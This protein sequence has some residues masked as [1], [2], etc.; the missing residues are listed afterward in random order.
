MTHSNT[1]PQPFHPGSGSHALG[2]GQTVVWCSSVSLTFI[3]HLFDST[4][5][6]L[7]SSP[8][9]EF[10]IT[11]RCFTLSF[12]ISD[13]TLSFLNRHLWGLLCY[14]LPENVT[15]FKNDILECRVNVTLSKQVSLLP[16]SCIYQSLC[17]RKFSSFCQ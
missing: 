4:C 5:L 11:P 16:C 15:I 6:E 3:V 2:T 9:Q 13:L 17:P 1:N 10:K 14:F 7:P 12:R 8:S